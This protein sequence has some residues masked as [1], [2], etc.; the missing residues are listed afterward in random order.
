MISLLCVAFTVLPSVQSAYQL[1]SQMATIIYLVMYLIMY[2]AAIRLRYSQP[3]V[4]RPF[5]VPGGNFGM[6]FVGVVGLLGA[7][8]AIVF[9]FIPPNQISTGSPAVYV[10]ILLAGCAIFVAIPFV[11]YAFHKPSWRAKDSDFEPFEGEAAIPAV[12]K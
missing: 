7:L 2:A 10:G 5:K 9:S 1:L 4:T 6:W 8:V 11:L 3:D 12:A